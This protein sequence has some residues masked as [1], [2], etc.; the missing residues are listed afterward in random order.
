MEEK[1]VSDSNKTFLEDVSPSRLQL[2][3]SELLR[4][5][6]ERKEDDQHLY[7]KI[8]Q[9]I[10]AYSEGM[11]I[12]VFNPADELVD[13]AL[14][15]FK[16][17][18]KERQS[19]EDDYLD[20]LKIYDLSVIPE[21]W[22]ES[23]KKML[24]LLMANQ[25]EES[26]DDFD[27]SLIKTKVHPSF[28]LS[29]IMNQTNTDC[30]TFPLCEEPDSDGEI[31]LKFM[32]LNSDTVSQIIQKYSNHKYNYHLLLAKCVE[33]SRE[34]LID[35]MSLYSSDLT[36]YFRKGPIG[37][38][39]KVILKW[40]QTTYKEN[41]LKSR[42]ENKEDNQPPCG[43][44]DAEK[45]YKLGLL[46]NTKVAKILKDA[47]VADTERKLGI[48]RVPVPPPTEVKKV[49]KPAKK[50]KAKKKVN[51]GIDFVM[52]VKGTD[53]VI[54][55]IKVN[56]N[57]SKPKK[58]KKPKLKSKCN[59]SSEESKSH[60]TTSEDLA[61]YISALTTAPADVPNGQALLDLTLK[62][63]AS[64]I[65]RAWKKYLESQ[66]S[67]SREDSSLADYKPHL[68]GINLI[69]CQF[70]RYLGKK[71]QK[72]G[73]CNLS[74]EKE[75]EL[76]VKNFSQEES[77]EILE[78][79]GDASEQIGRLQRFVREVWNAKIA[80][81]KRKIARDTA[82]CDMIYS[83]YESHRSRF[84]AT[85][86]FDTELMR[87][88]GHC[89]LEINRIDRVLEESQKRLENDFEKII[90]L[91]DTQEEEKIEID[92]KFE[93]ETVKFWANYGSEIERD[94]SKD[95]KYKDWESI[96]SKS[97]NTLW[98]NHKTR[99]KSKHH[100]GMKSYAKTI[101][102]EI[103]LE[104]SYHTS[105]LKHQK[106]RLQKIT[107]TLLTHRSADLHQLRTTLLKSHHT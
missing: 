78:R 41:L 16:D 8:Q 55:E 17:K 33:I 38:N 96:T 83:K 93:E 42:E 81:K 50:K 54:E 105:L 6:A 18:E 3:I 56:E 27:H 90:G 61:S 4:L 14:G 45:C 40:L 20:E 10:Q 19:I 9:K 34:K 65:Q 104:H 85:K 37:K 87:R 53:K 103:A 67:F 49:N 72:R 28:H 91:K 23:A 39:K 7:S 25:E 92:P 102:Q 74:V 69:Q 86:P 2:C 106:S 48:K 95:P 71:R 12:K 70:R 79:Y 46:Q 52:V 11:K 89:K 97:G 80:L 44:S 13:R 64:R 62:T 30:D 98:V 32:F 77:K 68:A 60:L 75:I 21:F 26:K 88:I 66:K 15:E 57:S 35:Q 59:K 36:L 82:E 24:L 76:K 5:M 100:P 58:K 1:L 94:L 107:S 31:P 101:K 63:A 99:H 29:H 73:G 22:N 51:T 43:V 84:L 47:M